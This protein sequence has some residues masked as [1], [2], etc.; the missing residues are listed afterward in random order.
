MPPTLNLCAARRDPP[1]T[2]LILHGLQKIDRNRF[3][4]WGANQFQTT[5]RLPKNLEATYAYACV[6]GVC[7]CRH[8]DR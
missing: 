3:F 2:Y 5:I 8:H 7:R 6:R 4:Y 1:R